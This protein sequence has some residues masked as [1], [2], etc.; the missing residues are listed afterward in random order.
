MT[1]KPAE[2][3][4]QD[5][6]KEVS[7]SHVNNIPAGKAVFRITSGENI[8][9]TTV[10]LKTEMMFLYELNSDARLQRQKGY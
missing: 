1:I 8:A 3:L 10:T 9:Q 2:I 6:K 5:D 7:E 4:S